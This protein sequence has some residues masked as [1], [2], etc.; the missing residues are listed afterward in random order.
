MKGELNLEQL[1]NVQAKGEL[2]DNELEGVVGGKGP[3]FVTTPGG[4]SVGWGG[5]G[6]G[7]GGWG[8]P[9]GWGGYGGY[10]SF[11]YG[12]RWW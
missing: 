10:R 11:G 9:W 5:G 6:W 8:R 3:G 4:V 1:D 12:R 7:W 2:S